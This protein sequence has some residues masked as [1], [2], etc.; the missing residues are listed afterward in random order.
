MGAMLEAVS[1]HSYRSTTLEEL[2]G[3]AGVSFTTF[4]EHFESKEACFFATFDEIVRQGRE[5]VGRAYR[6]E[7]NFEQRLRAGLEAFMDL[8]QEEPAAVNLVIA[9]SLSLG[10]RGVTH[11]QEANAQFEVLVRQS[12]E[13]GASE[14]KVSEVTTRAIVAGIQRVV[15]RRIRIGQLKE[16][17]G[18]VDELQRWA[19]SYRNP[20]DQHLLG[21]SASTAAALPAP[22]PSELSWDEPPNS[23][24]SRSMLTQRERIIRGTAH[25]VM[26]RGFPKLSIPAIS[27]N[28]GVSNQTFYEHFNSRQEAFLAAFEALLD[29]ALQ[30]TSGAMAKPGGSPD[31]AGVGLRT[32]LQYIADNEIFARIAFFELPTIGTAGL[33]AAESGIERFT[34]AI[35]VQELPEEF[36]E[37]VSEVIREAI[38]GGIWAVIQHEIAEDRAASLP[39]LAPEVLNLALTPRLSRSP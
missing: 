21:A 30:A 32:V 35:K 26:E 39:E 22:N 37:P 28:A 20:V 11:L 18:L 1:R 23:P 33:D 31:P 3:L 24:R 36:G 5:R 15:Y 38:G 27:S 16:L 14:A 17:P 2:V 12:F 25:A 34:A 10:A 8:V 4:Y 29:D 6:Q 13:Q 19:L 9:E 7:G